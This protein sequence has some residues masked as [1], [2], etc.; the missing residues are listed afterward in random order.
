[1]NVRDHR[2]SYDKDYYINFKLPDGTSHN[3][4]DTYL[5]NTPGKYLLLFLI[6]LL[7]FYTLNFL[8]VYN[9]IFIYF[10][11]LTVPMS[12]ASPRDSCTSLHLE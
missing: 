12:Y 8:L 6:L 11:G 1:M 10:L 3:I 9:V 7:F 2:F 5:P 4:I